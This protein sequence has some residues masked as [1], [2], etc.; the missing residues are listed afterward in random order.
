M[1]SSGGSSDYIPPSPQ[2]P[3]QSVVRP[4]TGAPGFVNFL[5]N[6]LATGF[7]PQME[8]GIMGQGGGAMRPPTISGMP[9]ESQGGGLDRLRQQLAMLLAQQRA[10]SRTQSGGDRG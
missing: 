2:G 6:G 3:P 10:P 1:A 9:A 7:T 4:P 8:A 5:G